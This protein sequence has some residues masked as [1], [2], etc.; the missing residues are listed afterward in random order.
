MVPETLAE[1][2]T[3]LNEEL[4]RLVEVVGNGPAGDGAR[5]RALKSFLSQL[6]PAI[7]ELEQELEG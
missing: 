4:E 5:F 3:V 7:D 6:I 1:A 2:E